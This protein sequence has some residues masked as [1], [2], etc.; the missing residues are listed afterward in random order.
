MAFT[1]LKNQEKKYFKMAKIKMA[2]RKFIRRNHDK[3]K[4]L[5]GRR[6]KLI[7][8]RPK[9]IHNKMRERRRGYPARP[10]MGMKSA[11]KERK[12]IKVVSNLREMLN[13]KKGEEIIIAKIGRKKRQEMEKRAQE[14]G[15][16]ILN[17]RKIIENEP[18]K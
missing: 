14:A 13:C 2:R 3:Y 17:Q 15:I 6:K 1:L 5:G 7:W 12:E 4:R 18:K 8:R 10:E 9:G 11:S 16:R